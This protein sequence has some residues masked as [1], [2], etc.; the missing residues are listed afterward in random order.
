VNNKI[1]LKNV[2]QR[3]EECKKILM[4]KGLEYMAGD[5]DRFANF[6]RIAKKYGVPTELVA[7]I[8]MEKHF[9]SITNFI[10][11]RCDGKKIEE[12]KLTEPISGRFI[13]A[14]NYLTLLDGI[15]YEETE[16]E[17]SEGQNIQEK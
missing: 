12:I 16:K 4:T 8:Y 7:A 17:K 3:F 6:K 5:D 9:D 14:I 15:I 2:D 10:R 1:F 11:L 13:D